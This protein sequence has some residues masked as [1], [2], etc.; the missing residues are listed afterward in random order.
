MTQKGNE[1]WSRFHR[2][3]DELSVYQ[4][5]KGG[6]RKFLKKGNSMQCEEIEGIHVQ[7]FVSYTERKIELGGKV[8]HKNIQ[9]Y[10]RY[11]ACQVVK[12]PNAEAGQV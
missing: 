4:V 12:G 7:V 3:S 8:P 6:K 5:E 2:G 11:F 9:E 1:K 10:G